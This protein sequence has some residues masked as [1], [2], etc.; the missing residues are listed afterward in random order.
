MFL[1]FRFLL[2]ISKHYNHRQQILEMKVSG[3]SGGRVRLQAFDILFFSFGDVCISHLISFSLFFHSI[4]LSR[5]DSVLTPNSKYQQLQL[6]LR[7]CPVA[8]PFCLASG[9]REEFPIPDR[10]LEHAYSHAYGCGEE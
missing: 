8:A 6:R 2:L 1:S 4:F 7:R 3:A 10:I 9:P 5:K